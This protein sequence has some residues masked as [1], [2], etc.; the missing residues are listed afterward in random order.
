VYLTKQEE[1]QLM[2]VQRV[3][4]ILKLSIRI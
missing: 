4:I 2:A 3:W 1:N